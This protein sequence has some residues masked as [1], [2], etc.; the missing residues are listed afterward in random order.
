MSSNGRF[1]ETS[2]SGKPV[3]LNGDTGWVGHIRLQRS[4][5]QIYLSNRKQLGFNLIGVI[6][7]HETGFNSGINI[8]GDSPFQIQNNGNWDVNQPIITSGSNPDNATEYDYWD[9]L[10]YYISQIIS[11]GTI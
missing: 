1:L 2:N 4:D 3:F 10:E 9:H 6:A 5:I 11:S 7:L 8:Y